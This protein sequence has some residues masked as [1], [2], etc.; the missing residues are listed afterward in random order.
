MIP[1]RN[2][3]KQIKNTQ[4]E[5]K[6]KYFKDSTVMLLSNYHYET[7]IIEKA[8]ELLIEDL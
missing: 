5:F 4:G 6:L 1:L 8:K 2:I 7:N 3:V